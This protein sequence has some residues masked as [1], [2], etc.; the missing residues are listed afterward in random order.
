[1][2]S[3]LLWV[4]VTATVSKG[5]KTHGASG[6]HCGPVLYGVTLYITLLL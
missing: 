3:T 5:K 2:R 4:K 1:M 6:A